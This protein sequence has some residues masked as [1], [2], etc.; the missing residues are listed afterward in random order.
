VKFSEFALLIIVF[1]CTFA[2]GPY[3]AYLSI[4]FIAESIGVDLNANLSIIQMV[5]MLI[6]FAFWFPL[7]CF[8]GM[9]IGL[10]IARPLCGA[11]AINVMGAGGFVNVPVLSS[12]YSNV[13]KKVYGHNS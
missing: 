13:V 3:L 11:S 8:I 5:C 4:M 7:W 10:I 6:F 1:L 2:I 12:V 9:L